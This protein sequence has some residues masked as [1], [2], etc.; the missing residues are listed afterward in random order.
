ML[1]DFLTRQNG[2]PSPF[3]WPGPATCVTTAPG[4]LERI[5]LAE[6]RS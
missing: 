2:A 4:G 6:T 1:K 5:R 3:L